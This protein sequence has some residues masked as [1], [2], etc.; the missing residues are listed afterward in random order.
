MSA[1]ETS[2]EFVDRMEADYPKGFTGFTSVTSEE[3]QNLIRLAKT[4]ALIEVHRLDVL[5]NEKTCIVTG[6]KESQFAQTDTV[7]TAVLTVAD[8]IKEQKA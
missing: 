3:Y 4:A 2:L 1:K 8:K 6:A 5:H 7:H